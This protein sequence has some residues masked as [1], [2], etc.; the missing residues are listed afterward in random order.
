LRGRPG[1]TCGQPTGSWEQT[2]L[3][4]SDS[5][6]PHMER[7]SRGGLDP[8]GCN[9]GLTGQ[10]VGQSAALLG[11]PG[12]GFGLRGPHGQWLTVVASV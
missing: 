8:T 7:Y 12:R 3:V 4:T 10:K 11:L 6:L 9:V 2:D 1:A 5:F